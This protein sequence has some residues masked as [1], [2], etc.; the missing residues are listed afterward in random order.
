MMKTAENC[1]MNCWGNAATADM[2]SLKL[3]VNLGTFDPSFKLLAVSCLITAC[4]ISSSSQITLVDG[5]IFRGTVYFSLKKVKW[6]YFWGTGCPQ[7]GLQHCPLPVWDW[8]CGAKAV[9]YWSSAVSTE[10]QLVQ[11]KLQLGWCGISVVLCLCLGL[12]IVCML[13]IQKCCRVWKNCDW[14]S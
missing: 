13:E 10:S 7:I 2:S 3:L 9:C 8:W 4:K 6:R 14:K 5:L 1:K 12:G 11:S